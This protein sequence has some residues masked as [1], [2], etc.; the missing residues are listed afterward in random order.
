MVP[1][2]VFAAACGNEVTLNETLETG[3]PL[4]LLSALIVASTNYAVSLS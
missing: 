2:N 4:N 1:Y 3:F